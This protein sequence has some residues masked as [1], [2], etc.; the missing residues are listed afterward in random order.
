M[1]KSVFVTK[2]KSSLC[3]CIICRREAVEASD[4]HIIPK[5]LGGYMH[6]W[7]VC[8]ECN[9]ILGHKVDS[10]I[11]NQYFIG[12]ERVVRAAVENFRKIGLDTIK[13]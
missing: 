11:T 2:P 12:F 1:D 7:N 8:Q 3:T 4:E 6:T 10:L 13:R 9:S 5:A